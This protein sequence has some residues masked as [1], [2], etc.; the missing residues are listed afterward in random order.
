MMK[1]IVALCSLVLMSITSLGQGAY[2]YETECLGSE[3]DGSITVK[4]WGVGRNYIDGL[5]Q[6]KKVAVRDVIFKGIQN[7]KPDCN[8][9]PLVL[10]PHGQQT[11]EDYFFTLLADNGEY[12]KFVSAK[13]EKLS[14]KTKR[15]KEK[16][17]ESVKVSAIIRVDRAGLKKKLIQDG[18]IK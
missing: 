15:N 3:M 4:A 7:G 8:R 10:D 14:S 18:I 9:A 2:T 17:P 16:N 13:D 5:E 6:A 1:Y 12:L 11:N